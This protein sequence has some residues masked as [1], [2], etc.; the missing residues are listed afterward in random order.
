MEKP[1]DSSMETPSFGAAAGLQGVTL[2][3]LLQA[4]EQAPSAIALLR[5]PHLVYEFANAR[6]RALSPHSNMVGRVYGDGRPELVVSREI[7]REALRTGE[8]FSDPRQAVPVTLPD[9]R[10]FTAFASVRVEPLDTRSG[11]R[12]GRVPEDGR[13]LVIAQEL[14]SEV[15]ARAELAA[16]IERS[17]RDREALARSEARLRRIIDANIVGIVFWKLDGSI[18]DANDAFLRITGF[19]RDDLRSGELHWTKLRSSVSMQPMREARAHL[20]AQGSFP[21]ME[22]L[23]R[24]KDGQ[25]VPVL[26]AGAQQP[27]TDGGVTFVLDRSEIERKEV[28][29]KGAEQR[30]RTLLDA[31]PISLFAFDREGQITAS[32][33]PGAGGPENGHPAALARVTTDLLRNVPEIASCIRRV[34]A[35]Q[36]TVCQAA[37]G[38]R[39]F[40]VLA[41]PIRGRESR[42][43]GGIGVA[44]D[45]TER[46]RATEEKE[47]LRERLL[48]IQKL[49]SLGI[50]AGGIAHDFNNLLAGILGNA[51]AALAELPPGGEGRGALSDVIVGARRATELTQ[52]MLAYA[53]RASSQPR[54]LDLSE[55][56]RNLLAELQPGVRDRL[57]LRLEGA[58]PPVRGDPDQLRQVLLAL[59]AN[60]REA[61]D[62]KGGTISFSTRLVE[63]GPAAGE[64]F[65]GG[66][67]LPPGWYAQL[68]I[69]DDGAGMDE[70]TRA[71]AFDPFFSTKFAG[72]GLGLAAV[73]GIVRAH[74][75]GVRVRSAPG[76]G[77]SV[78]ILLPTGDL[79]TS[80]SAQPPEP[81]AR[82]VLIVDDEPQVRSAA[83]R[84]LQALGHTVLESSDGA[85]AVETLR[86][87]KGQIGVVL[88]DLTMPGPSGAQTFRALREIDPRARIILCS[89]YPPDIAASQMGEELPSSFLS[90]PFTPEELVSRVEAALGGVAQKI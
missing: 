11:Q 48:Q 16:Q 55:Q 72:R 40:E 76:A 47:R 89:G 4:F 62:V 43:E 49:E 7:L 50:L 42:I 75:G 52:Q 14:T 29:L 78:E 64:G 74:R 82:A 13:L 87:H 45:V 79:R 69:S 57:V 36:E 2:S 56:V 51:A 30:L 31:A 58:L 35:G 84:L 68:E 20:D 54:S 34:L 8:P 28:A 19:G 22:M 44:V 27:E 3:Q 67:V 59:F 39:T 61:L 85:E 63:L 37:V 90:K 80:A 46:T 81:Q 23:L 1:V 86:A 5:G 38:P 66:T 65:A 53:G 17:Q 15:Q 6:W 41:R 71:R 83:R 9:G 21:A 24:R 12:E 60:A 26:L 18:V 88:L 70:P 32:E 10:A 77:T 25:F 33:G 73:L